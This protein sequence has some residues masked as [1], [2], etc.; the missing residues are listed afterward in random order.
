VD[1]KFEARLGLYSETLIIKTKLNQNNN[2][3]MVVGG[4]GKIEVSYKRLYIV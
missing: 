2:N 3:K 4:G 1:C